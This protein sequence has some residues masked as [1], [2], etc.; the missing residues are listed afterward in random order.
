MFVVHCYLLKKRP[1]YIPYTAYMSTL[2]DYN[3]LHCNSAH[4][5]L[6]LLLLLWLVVVE[7]A[8][9]VVVVVVVVVLDKAESLTA[10]LS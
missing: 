5:L 10:N 6:L 7:A 9:V 2:M 8:V 4:K 3:N 1:A